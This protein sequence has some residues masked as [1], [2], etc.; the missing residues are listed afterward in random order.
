MVTYRFEDSRSGDCV[1][2]HLAGYRGILQVD[3]YAAYN[4]LAKPERTNDV[5]LLAGCWAHVR[6]RFYELHAN[7]S[8]PF[9]TRIIEAMAPL[10]QI[11]DEIRSC[12]PEHRCTIR[13]QRSSAIADG[14]FALW[15]RELPR[16]GDHC[17]PVDHGQ[18]QWRRSL[19]VSKANARAHRRR[20]A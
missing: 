9:A 1:A 8:S 18:D 19:Q 10:W 14:L 17:H 12:N 15:E 6:R 20:L 2:R 4:R 3:G 5:V 7:E 11:E 13:Q 16:L